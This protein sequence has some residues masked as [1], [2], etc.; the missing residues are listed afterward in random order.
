[1][2]DRRIVL[3]EVMREI[4]VGISAFYQI[5][6]MYFYSIFVIFK[7]AHPSSYDADFY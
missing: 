6:V 4:V 7:E 3:T 2:T 1:M 5:T